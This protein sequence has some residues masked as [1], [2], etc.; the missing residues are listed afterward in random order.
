[1]IFLVD[2]TLVPN[3]SHFL[4]NPT[5]PFDFLSKVSKPG[6]MGN[7]VEKNTTRNPLLPDSSSVRVLKVKTLQKMLAFLSEAKKITK[8]IFVWSGSINKE[9]ARI[10]RQSVKK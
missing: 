10:R 7:R 4:K 2:Y 3:L 5:N 6:S 8:N 9:V 1:M